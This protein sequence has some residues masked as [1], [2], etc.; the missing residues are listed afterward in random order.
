MKITKSIVCDIL[1]P[2]NIVEYTPGEAERTFEK[3]EFV[4]GSSHT[5]TTDVLY[6]STA[7]QLQK[8]AA[9]RWTAYAP[10][11]GETRLLR[12]NSLKNTA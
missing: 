5:F 11:A 1:K 6:I 8:A 7:G 10:C 4:T 3:V 2:H 9:P 12:R